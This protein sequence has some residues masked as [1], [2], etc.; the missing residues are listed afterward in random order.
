MQSRR[1]F[2]CGYEL[3]GPVDQKCPECGAAP[4]TSEETAL[5][6]SLASLGLFFIAFSTTAAGAVFIYIDRW[7]SY[8]GG[9]PRFATLQL[10]A[11]ATAIASVSVAPAM[12]RRTIRFVSIACALVFAVKI[13]PATPLPNWGIPL[14]PLIRLDWIGLFLD[15]A[16]MLAVPAAFATALFTTSEIAAGVRLPSLSK[17]RPVH[18]L[19]I[20]LALF[21]AFPCAKYLE[22]YLNRAHVAR[23]NALLP[24]QVTAGPQPMSFV[25]GLEYMLAWGREMI[26]I[27]AGSWLTLV[28][29]CCWAQTRTLSRFSSGT[30]RL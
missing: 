17:I 9:V 19:L 10:L 11:I 22:P 23:L 3:S 8:N 29:I 30:S 4:L 28:A 14:H 16:E 6:S 24:S 20:G 12:R 2:N 27:I 25:L 7:S 1:C 13:S 5:Q 18:A 21:L 26:W 15:W